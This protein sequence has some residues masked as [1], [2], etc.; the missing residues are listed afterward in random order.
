MVM[1]I[2]SYSQPSWRIVTLSGALVLLAYAGLPIAFWLCRAAAPLDRIADGLG[3]VAVA[4]AGVSIAYAVAGA[5]VVMR[6]LARDLGHVQPV[7]L[8]RTERL[9]A[10]LHFW[11]WLVGIIAVPFYVAYLALA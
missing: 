5:P 8:V 6:L 7:P 2:E 1:Q 4:L 10:R 3:T 9:F 11:L